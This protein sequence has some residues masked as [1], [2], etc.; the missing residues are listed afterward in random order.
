MVCAL[1]GLLCVVREYFNPKNPFIFRGELIG[2][3]IQN[4]IIGLEHKYE[5]IPYAIEIIVS[6][7]LILLNSSQINIHESI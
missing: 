5:G 6:K 4:L 1:R 3:F 2:Y 7:N